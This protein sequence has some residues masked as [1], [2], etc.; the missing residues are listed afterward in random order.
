MKIEI[1]LKGEIGTFSTESEKF[2]GIGGILK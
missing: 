2:S 1:F